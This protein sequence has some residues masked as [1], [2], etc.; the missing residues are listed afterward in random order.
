MTGLFRGT[1]HFYCWVTSV[2][3]RVQQIAFR[4]TVHTQRVLKPMFDWIEK[5]NGKRPK[6]AE[7]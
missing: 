7:S 6:Y 5:E 3:S 4:A 2:G 1:Q